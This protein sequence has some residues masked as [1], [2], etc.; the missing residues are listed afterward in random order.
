MCSSETRRPLH[1]TTRW[2]TQLARAQICLFVMAAYKSLQEARGPRRAQQ[3]R[4]AAAARDARG[5]ERA[6]AQGEEPSGRGRGIRRG[7]G[8]ETRG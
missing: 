6:Q 5:A 8:G 1:P 7:V 3:Q 2:S 4:S